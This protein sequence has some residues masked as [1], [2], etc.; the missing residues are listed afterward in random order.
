METPTSVNIAQYK[1]DDL[2]TCYIFFM[3]FPKTS[4]T[5]LAVEFVNR[6]LGLNPT[7]KRLSQ[8]THTSVAIPCKELPGIHIYIDNYKQVP[9][10]DDEDTDG[11]IKM[12]PSRVLKEA[13]STVLDDI[14]TRYPNVQATACFALELRYKEFIE[15][16]DGKLQMNT[17]TKRD[18]FSWLRGRFGNKKVNNSVCCANA[19]VVIAAASSPK[20][21]KRFYTVSELLAICLIG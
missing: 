9:G 11:V 17:V 2:V 14:S 1:D 12:Y 15:L 19:E 20:L 5:A 6:L 4:V 16:I 18:F 7:S 13:C 10:Q 8:F 21:K 3:M